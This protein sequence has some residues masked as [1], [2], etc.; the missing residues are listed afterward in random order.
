MLLERKDIS[1]ESERNE[2][3]NAVFRCG[4]F[5]T[6]DMIAFSESAEPLL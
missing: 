2:F 4:H 1:G 5:T 6:V 3:G